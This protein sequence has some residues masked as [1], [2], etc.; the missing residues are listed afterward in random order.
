MLIE[1][2]VSSNTL[3]AQE[4][5]VSLNGPRRSPSSFDISVSQNNT[6][7][8]ADALKLMI[9]NNGG[10]NWSE[11]QSPIDSP[12]VV[13]VNPANKNM[14]IVGKKDSV[15]YSDNSGNDWEIKLVGVYPLRFSRSPNDADRVW[16]GSKYYEDQNG[17]KKTSLRSSNDNGINWK[18][19]EYF[20]DSVKTNITDVAVRDGND[21]EVWV[22]GANIKKGAMGGYKKA[23]HKGLWRTLNALDAVPQ[24]EEINVMK[25]N[26]PRLNTVA[27]LNDARII[28]G[29]DNGDIYRREDANENNWKKVLNLVPSRSILSLNVTGNTVIAATEKDL[30][31]S[32]ANGDSATWIRVIAD[33]TVQPDKKIIFYEIA[34]APNN[35]SE[36][37][38]STSFGVYKTSDSG[39]SWNRL[40]TNSM[41]VLS[42]VVASNNIIALSITTQKELKREKIKN[43]P[44]GI[45]RCDLVTK[46][47]DKLDIDAIAPKFECK[48][49]YFL[50]PDTIFALGRIEHKSSDSAVILVS[51]D[52][53]DSWTFS[54]KG[55]KMSASVINGIVPWYGNLL[56]FGKIDK[57]YNFIQSS[58]RG[59]SWTPYSSTSSKPA[60]E[61]ILSVAVT[62]HPTIKAYAVVKK[63]GNDCYYE[64]REEGPNT[65][66]VNPNYRYNFS[67][68]YSCASYSIPNSNDV[69]LYLAGK[70]G[71]YRGI[72]LIVPKKCK[73]VL[74]YLNRI[75]II[76]EGETDAILSSTTNADNVWENISEQLT[77]NENVERIYNI[78]LVPLP[79]NPP[80]DDYDIYCATDRGI[81][82]IRYCN[83]CENGQGKKITYNRSTPTKNTIIQSGEE[84]HFLEDV[85]VPEGSSFIVEAGATLLFDE[86]VKLL[87][88][89]EFNAY[90]TAEQPVR[91]MSAYEGVLWNGIYLTPGSNA[92]F[93][94][95]EIKSAAVGVLAS[96]ADVTLHRSSVS[97]CRIGVCVYGINDEQQQIDSCNFNNNAWGVV[98]LNGANA[99]LRNNT[100]SGGQKGILIDAS[101]PLLFGNTIENN[102]QVGVVVYGGGYPRFGD[103]ASDAQG[104]NIVQGN[105]L[106]QLL[107]VQGYAFLGFLQR[108]CI[109]HIGGDNLIAS[110]DPEAP[111]CVAVENS[112]ITSMATDWGLANVTQENF[113]QEPNSKIIFDC[114]LQSP[115]NDEETRLWNALEHRSLAN[116]G[117]AREDYLWII[118]NGSE[119]EALH[120][121]AE[122][123]EMTTQQ[124]EESGD[125]AIVTEFQSLLEAAA[126]S[127]PF[128]D[129]RKS[130]NILLTLAATRKEDKYEAYEKFETLS[131]LQFNDDAKISSLLTKNV[132]E[133]SDMEYDDEAIATATSLQSQF[134]DDERT[135]IA[136]LLTEIITGIDLPQHY[137]KRR[138]FT[139]AMRKFPE[140]KPST[141]S[142]PKSFALYQNY[143][144]PFNPTTQFVFDVPNDAHV[145]ITLYDI[146]GRNVATVVN[147]T[148]P[149][150]RYKVEWNAKNTASGAYFVKMTSERFSQLRKILLVK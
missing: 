101:S 32:R 147:E 75:F 1:L 128:P 82:S 116:Y 10:A 112:A 50:G 83:T 56:A 45:D 108:D 113:L 19:D 73:Q 6:I 58:D 31:V 67:D 43:I 20:K 102:S 87:I 5:W 129:V 77:E 100:I 59:H 64:F 23:I 34:I 72:Q 35:V 107:T 8:S 18:E 11:T 118:N 46:T 146:L 22:T 143:P 148:K 70:K 149:A 93:E 53:G 74:T 16:L 96:K 137:S 2:G 27:I 76:R 24:W 90:G 7:Y 122:L 105:A 63:P 9:T 84:V 80:G 92:Y 81:F 21:N 49:F 69:S 115:S 12:F 99:F 40:V 52:N 65:R 17:N 29:A 41:P 37:Y 25:R 135:Q 57:A 60:K 139:V 89:G 125:E 111:L 3:V 91:I 117:Q 145:E 66:W 138:T 144:N 114:L 142:P 61:E 97:N 47:W 134:P 131:S 36:W 14:V 121:L 127:H 55:P 136:G 28:V 95:V 140:R 133:S 51:Y 120:A 42:N 79:A 103:I 54:F 44:G 85:F 126:V 119:E 141:N 38:L 15:L 130:A 13:S 4:E 98:V 124:F 106:T 62:N 86:G 71:L 110:A 48:N 150:G 39:L 94:N 104:L 132:F 68:L 109:T 78:A 26:S 88:E 33:S 30:Y 123:S